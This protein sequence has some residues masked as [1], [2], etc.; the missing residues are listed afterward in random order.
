M[1]VG[2]SILE[3]CW[4]SVDMARELGWEEE[5]ERRRAGLYH[6]PGSIAARRD[7]EGATGPRTRL[8]AEQRH[9]RDNLKAEQD[10]GV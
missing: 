7:Q 10:N 6:H 8:E 1:A 5:G 9:K 2:K 4:R 3:F